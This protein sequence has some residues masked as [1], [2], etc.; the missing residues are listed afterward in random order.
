M[1]NIVFL[2]IMHTCHLRLSLLTCPKRLKPI[3]KHVQNDENP[4]HR[5]YNIPLY[6]L[7]NVK[8]QVVAFESHI[9]LSGCKV[10]HIGD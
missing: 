7:R 1:D 4:T 8:L 9:Y 6:I 5:L 10:C 2:D 3:N